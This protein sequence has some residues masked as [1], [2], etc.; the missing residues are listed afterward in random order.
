MMTVET[1]RQKTG[2]KIRKA[3]PQIHDIRCGKVAR[4]SLTLP[5][6]TCGARAIV[7]DAVSPILNGRLAEMDSAGS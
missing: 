2:K 4:R 6:L 7:F 5:S 1:T 3:I